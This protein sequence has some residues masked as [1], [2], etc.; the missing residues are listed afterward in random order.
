VCF[1]CFC[2]WYDDVWT[3][4]RATSDDERSIKRTGRTLATM[5]GTAN[6]AVCGLTHCSVFPAAGCMSR[7]DML[8]LYGIRRD[9]FEFL[10]FVSF[11]CVCIV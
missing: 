11:V 1:I 3:I 5:R 6:V 4:V 10:L 9:A 2:Y 7:G 8:V